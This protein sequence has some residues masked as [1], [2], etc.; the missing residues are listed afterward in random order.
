VLSVVVDTGRIV[1]QSHGTEE[2]KKGEEPRRKWWK[3][4]EHVRR[5]TQRPI[6][7]LISQL[8]LL[9]IIINKINL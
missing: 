3:E 2:E 7:K 5:E 4:G 9:T 1:S 8:K 6:N